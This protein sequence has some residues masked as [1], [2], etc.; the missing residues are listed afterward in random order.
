MRNLFCNK[1]VFR[2]A[3]SQPLLY[4]FAGQGT[5]EKGM[6]SDLLK[7]DEARS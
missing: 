3:Q 4:I 2:F 5:Q 1:T 6:L 7:I